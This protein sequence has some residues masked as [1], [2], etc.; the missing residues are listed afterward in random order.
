MRS[1]HPREPL[2]LVPTDDPPRRIKVR[3][4]T[5]HPLDIEGRPRSVPLEEL[6]VCHHGHRCGLEQDRPTH[7]PR[8]TVVDLRARAALQHQGV[9]VEPYPG[10]TRPTAG[11]RAVPSRSPPMY[12][13]DGEPTAV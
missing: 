11:T 1:M 5:L 10:L 9:G 2:D 6:V 3:Q 4:E 8:R 13:V 7:C 12:E